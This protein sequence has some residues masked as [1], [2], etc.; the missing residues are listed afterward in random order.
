MRL[1]NRIT[2]EQNEAEAFKSSITYW[3]SKLSALTHQ[4][5]SSVPYAGDKRESLERIIEDYQ[6]ITRRLQNLV[7]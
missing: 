1:F 6:E 4:M 7:Q 5:S 3:S 2:Q